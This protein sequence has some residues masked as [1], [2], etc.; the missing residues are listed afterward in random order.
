VKIAGS[1]KIG[2]SLA[3]IALLAFVS[4]LL[5]T[6]YLAQKNLQQTL[7]DRFRLENETRAASI[8]YFFSERNEDLRN[9]ASSREVSVFFE[10]RA[11]GMSMEY[12]LKQSLPP[13][14]NLF[15]SLIDRS[16]IGRDS[17][18]LQ[19]VFLDEKGDL[20]VRVSEPGQTRL[21]TG[22]TKKYYAPTHPAGMVF[23]EGHDKSTVIMTSYFF[24]GRYA[25]QIIA[26][27]NRNYVSEHVVK[28]AEHP[29][30]TLSLATAGK[31]L[32]IP[33]ALG[34]PDNLGNQ[35]LRYQEREPGKE[36]RGMIG[37][38][39]VVRDTPFLLV[40]MSP[41][42]ALLGGLAPGRLLFGM[43]ILALVIIGGGLAMIRVR[44]RSVLLQTMLDAS[45][46]LEQNVREKNAQLEREIAER[47]QAEDALRDSENRYRIL[48]E[49]SPDVIFT[50][51]LEDCR[52]LSLNQIFENSSGW[53][54]T[55]WI[56]RSFLDVI[57]PEDRPLALDKH[58]EAVKGT[59]VPRYD[60]RFLTRSGAC[61][62]AEVTTAPLVQNGVASGMLGIARDIT[63]R[64]ILEEQLR[65]AV[66]MQAV[67]QLAGGIAHDFN[68]ILSV[69]IGACDLVLMDLETGDP[70]R[71]KIEMI[72][73][74]AERGAQLTRNLLTFC[75]KQVVRML[76]RDL[77]E[78]MLSA[79]PLIARLIRED[80]RFCV[81]LFP[82]RLVC[83][84][85]STQ[86][87]QML[88]NLAANA[89]DAMTGGGK[90][91]IGSGRLAVDAA[92]RRERG[93]GRDG[94]YAVL[95]IE[96]T[97]TGMDE[98]VRQRIFEPFF[99]TKD[100]GKGTGLGLAT[101]FG[102]VKQH[103]GYI[104]VKSEVGRGTVFF[105]YLPLIRDSA[106]GART[107]AATG[108]RLRGSGTVLVAEDE[109]AVRTV[110][111]KTLAGSGYRVI[112][113]YDGEDAEIKFREHDNE[114]DLLILD[115]IMPKKNGKQAFDSIK[116]I[117]PDLQCLFLSGYAADIIT[118]SGISEKEGAFLQKPVPPHLLL[119]KVREILGAEP[120]Q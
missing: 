52:I 44:T 7:L 69:I 70:E 20:L 110:I 43:G 58:R 119:E 42:E 28:S 87:E 17:A 27:I 100:V 25:G 26:W 34:L 23:A 67:G 96:D 76:A 108:K 115:V 107:T 46:I 36:A 30:W 86:I 81:D 45:R 111:T 10:N 38:A 29:E 114:I 78:I 102:I 109:S 84:A 91:T 60:L 9:L 93:F 8:S 61:R 39:S 33:G 99:T 53:P 68:N 15:A 59:G 3:V 98:M 71:P 31:P 5:T 13:I 62:I 74:S 106:E 92:F 24:K 66:K 14:K 77:N 65:H 118:S 89:R 19:I 103:N 79:E 56:G 16:R 21:P 113:A 35:P 90:F 50:L 116:K 88:M 48:V 47:K 94:E 63:E 95:T 2:I 40:A 22:E 112:E 12:G 97:G 72:L 37:M 51:S 64:N 80:V 73:S 75:R 49:T 32:V 105:I 101:V 85:D 83:M 120:V 82:G 117:R 55:E 54:R 4:F 41:A 18:Y 1:Y 57:H 11:L 104:E 6:N